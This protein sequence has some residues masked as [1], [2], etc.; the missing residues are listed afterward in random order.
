MSEIPTR[1]EQIKEKMISYLE[2][3]ENKPLQKDI[4]YLIEQSPRLFNLKTIKDENIVYSFL[5]NIHTYFKN[6]YK[7]THKLMSKTST[8]NK[9]NKKENAIKGANAIIDYLDGMYCDNID[10]SKIKTILRDFINNPDKYKNEPITY[11]ITKD[12]LRS[13]LRKIIP[14][15][16]KEIEDFVKGLENFKI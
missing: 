6:I 7:E 1:D 13:E 10:S 9:R 3:I 4:D 2:L 8:T 11:T 16:S 5:F 14:N 15:K 12:N